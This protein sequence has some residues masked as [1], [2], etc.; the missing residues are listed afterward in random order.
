MSG[1]V[2]LV[3]LDGA[4]IDRRLLQQMTAFLSFRGPDGVETRAIGQAGFGYAR[5]HIGEPTASERP[6]LAVGSRYLIAGDVRIDARSAVVAAASESGSA[7]AA[8]SD[9]AL[10]AH[11]YSVWGDRCVER[12]LGDFSFAIWDADRRRLFCA[13]DQLGVRPL[14]FAQIGS[15]VAVSNSRR[16]LSRRVMS[17]WVS[18]SPKRTL[19]SIS[20]GPF[21]VSIR[22]A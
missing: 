14:Y 17:T 16:S 2:A 1:F 13:R 6:P 20:F 3:N 21:A 22:P 19:Y 4:P 12:L 10:L 11:C 7:S 9:L 5:L 8:E 18:G 15:T